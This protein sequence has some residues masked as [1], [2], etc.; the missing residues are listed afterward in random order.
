MD[1]QI[2]KGKFKKIH[3]NKPGK[4][5]IIFPS[6]EIRFEQNIGTIQLKLPK[7]Y[8]LGQE[9]KCVSGNYL[10]GTQIMLQLAFLA[11]FFQCI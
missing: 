10:A 9:M 4:I 2:I 3:Y 8:N 6:K 1:G 11:T 5:L 7:Q